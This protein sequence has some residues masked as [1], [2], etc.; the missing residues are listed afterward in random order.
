MWSGYSYNTRL[1]NVH[2]GYTGN[3]MTMACIDDAHLDKAASPER[4]GRRPADSRSFPEAPFMPSASAAK[5]TVTTEFH[6]ASH[7]GSCK[8]HFLQKHLLR[9]HINAKLERQGNGLMQR[10]PAGVQSKAPLLAFA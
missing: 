8:S 7:S 10:C 3:I 4:S 2:E 5:T 1:S 6:T 9:R